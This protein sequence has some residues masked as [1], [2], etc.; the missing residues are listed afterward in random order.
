MIFKES[1]NSNGV[2]E[3]FLKPYNPAQTEDRIYKL[4]EKSGFFNPDNLPGDKPFTIIMPPT[5][6][7]GSLHAGHALVMTIEDIMIRYKRMRGH[8]TLWL[9]GLDHAGIETQAVYEK[10]LEK[11][12]RSRFDMS[13]EELYSEILNFTLNNSKNIKSQIKS[14]GA[15]CDWSREKFTLD[16]D[17]VNLVYKNFK[18]LSE[19]GLL[20]RGSRIVS[21]CPKHRT[22]FS[23]LEILDEE[24]V[25]PFYYLKYGPFTIAT[26]R[27]ETKFGDKYV[28]M[29][30]DDKRYE[31][32]KHGQKIELEWINGPITAT[33]IKDEAIDMEFGTGVMTITPWHDTADFEIAERHGLD[34]EQIIGEDGKLLPIAGEFTGMK[35]AEARQKIIEKLEGKGLVEKVD[36]NYKHVVR[37]CYKCGTVIEPQIKSQWFVRMKPLAEKALEKINTGEITYLPEHYKKITIHWLEN[38]IDWNISRQIV[39]GIPIPA[40]I[41]E[42]CGEGMVDLDNSVKSCAKCGG[43]VRQDNDTFDTWFSSSQW[44]YATLQTLREKDFET[45]YPTDVM[46]TAGEIIFFWVARMVM[47]GLHVTG[48][49]PFKTVYLHGLVLD[50]K[51]R[52]MSKSKGNVINPLDLTAKYGTDALRI[53]LVIGNTPGTS[54]ALAEDRIKGYKNFANK[55]WNIA[56]YVLSQVDKFDKSDKLNKELKE[57]FDDLAKDVTNDMENF[58]FYIAAEK[59]YHYIWHRFADEILEE[60]KKNPELPSTIHYLLENS[61]KLLHPFMPFITE[62]IWQELK[63]L[64]TEFPSALGNSVSKSEPRTLLMIEPW[65]FD[66]AQSKP[67]KL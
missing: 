48:E 9:P 13:R 55:L 57:E 52:K 3:K 10:Q 14:M 62:E 47:L 41:C 6:A 25:D 67:A 54:L 58:R 11:E 27:P 56:R 65:P 20:Y 60:S 28:V 15:S 32:Y 42:S 7:N 12:G 16:E 4:W 19:D 34:K 45:F 59:I 43:S 24:R 53:A 63:H 40:K 2:N 33:I 21:W 23:D 1:K 61:L 30:P 31:D 38:I 22:A 8:K 36:T 44:P 37:T 64:E 46:E 66:K 50:A 26:A 39:W 35:I 5:N 49:L 17:I 29:H 18:R 51:G